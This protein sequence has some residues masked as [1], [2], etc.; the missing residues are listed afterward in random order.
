[1]EPAPDDLVRTLPRGARLLLRAAAAVGFA[2]LFL[3]LGALFSQD[4]AA[5]DEPPAVISGLVDAAVP[6]IVAKPLAP[7]TEPVL[8]VADPIVTPIVTP[9]VDRVVSPLVSAASMPSVMIPS[10]VSPSAV[11][12]P[13][14]ELVGTPAEPPVSRSGGGLVATAA[15]AIQP[16]SARVTPRNPPVD[17]PAGSPDPTPATI[18]ASVAAT[19]AADI[20]SPSLPSPAGA[21]PTVTPEHAQQR[22]FPSFEHDT[23]PD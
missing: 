14:G 19:G 11:S 10:A 3:A 4:R 2:L 17:E 12:P 22:T 1:M 18:G 13:T 7:V 16:E 5:A 23:S 21:A 15:P 6:D 20:H 9:V 8:A